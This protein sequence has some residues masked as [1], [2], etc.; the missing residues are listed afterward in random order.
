VKLF[1]ATLQGK[2]IHIR[3]RIAVI[4][5]GS[6][7]LIL[8]LLLIYVYTRPYRVERDPTTGI[9]SAYTTILEKVQMHF[10]RK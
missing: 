2:P 4:A 7:A 10:H 6:I 9:V 8:V 1:N 5:T 3:K